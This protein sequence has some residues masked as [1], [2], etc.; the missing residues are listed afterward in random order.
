MHCVSTDAKRIVVCNCALQNKT[1][2]CDNQG[3]VANL[4]INNAQIIA[5]LKI[6]GKSHESGEFCWQVLMNSG[7]HLEPVFG[8]IHL[9]L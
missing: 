6:D 5:S 4:D 8:N 2:V 9:C 1:S 7:L 3:R